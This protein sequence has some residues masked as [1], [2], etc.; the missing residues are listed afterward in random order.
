[1]LNCRPHV[2]PPHLKNPPTSST[3]LRAWVH[4]QGV[5]PHAGFARCHG[6]PG[7]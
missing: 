4:E 3:Y 1:M 7:R 2:P 6:E 5:A